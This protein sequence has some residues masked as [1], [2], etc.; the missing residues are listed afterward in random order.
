M[1]TPTT[2]EKTPEPKFKI[3]ARDFS[4]LIALAAI[5][6]FFAIMSPSFMSARNLSIL[7][8]DLSI[9]A[10]LAIG[11]LLVIVP[12]HIDLS[13]GSGVGLIGGL[14]AVLVFDHNLSAPVAMGIGL[15]VALVLWTGMGAL[16]VFE[17][18]PAFIITLG[19]LLIFKG[20]HWLTIHNATIPV[21]QGGQNNIYSLL[22]TWYLPPSLG[23]GLA[24]G[25]ILAFIW[26]NLHA[27]KRRQAHGLTVSDTEIFILRFFITAQIILLFVLVAN[28]YRGLP[29]SALI[30]GGV[31]LAVHFF[32]QHTPFGRYLYAIGDNEEAAFVSGIPVK[33]VL[34]GAFAINGAIVALTG[35]LQ[36]AY[37][38]ASTTTVGSLMEL[39]A[40]A[41]C[42]IGGT[43]LK[44]GRGTVVGVL[45][46]ALIMASLLNGMTLMAVSPEIKFIARGVV[47]ALAVW[48]DVRLARR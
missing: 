17:R 14:A 31:A 26:A 12:G 6:A 28:Q 7:L 25:T 29:L 5:W 43:S 47:L 18:I 40:I 24:A 48:T 9:T 2:Q 22:T 35:Y 37:A 38:G 11:M 8:I 20:V 21:V 36:T 39:D 23:M 1:T 13:V 27:R 41:A 42:V 15:L 3:S 33:K 46:G 4:M 45:F 16:I 10:V 44:G 34:I 30:L 32:T 19:G